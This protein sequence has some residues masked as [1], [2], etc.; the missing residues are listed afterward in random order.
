[1]PPSSG[2]WEESS[3]TARPCGMKKRRAATSQSVMAPGPALAA[4]ETH[5]RPM[6]AARLK[7]TR[8]RRFISRGSAGVC[9]VVSVKM[10][11]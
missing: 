3:T 6:S 11:F 2:K 8:S 1:M 5:V 4:V 9:S 7:S 10:G